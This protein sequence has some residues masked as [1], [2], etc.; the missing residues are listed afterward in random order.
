MNL[1]F[2]HK[3]D[4]APCAAAKPIVEAV[5]A[6]LGL[7]VQYVDAE[8]PANA[9]LVAEHKVKAVPTL[10]IADETS[11]RIAGFYGKMIEPERILR[12]LGA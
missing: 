2:Y 8:V 1:V 10:V 11:R 7:V 5:A 9:L 6:R 3:A 4:C 12:F